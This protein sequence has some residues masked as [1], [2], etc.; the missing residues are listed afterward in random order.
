[1]A[2]LARVHPSFRTP[3]LAVTTHALLAFALAS[4]GSF[5]TLLV[6][7]NVAVLLM[8]GVVC[9]GIFQLRRKNVRTGG[10]PFVVPGGP[11]VPIAAAA[12]LIWL[13]ST[14]TREEWLATGITLLLASALYGASSITRR[15]GGG[16]R[17]DET[18]EDT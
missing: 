12:V 17:V 9:V 16:A 18:R 8:Y 15:R 3:W 7:A 1:M 14:A 2:W 6:V 10:D 11:V 13:L 4:T 5:A